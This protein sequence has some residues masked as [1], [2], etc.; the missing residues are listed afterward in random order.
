MT[1]DATS[2]SGPRIICIGDVL[3]DVVARLSGPLQIGS[4]AA[5]TTALRGGGSA[6]NTACWLEHAGA[7]VAL[8]ARVGADMLG[9][10]SIE[11]LGSGVARFVG[12]DRSTPTGTCVVL[13]APNGERTM[14]PD[15][16][17]NATLRP[18]HLH[19]T[20]FTRGGHLH[21]SGYALF[22][23]ARIAALRALSLARAAGMT[24][25]V[26]AAS[27][28]PLRTLG[29]DTFFGLVGPQLLLFANQAEARALTGAADSHAAAAELSRRVGHAVVTRGADTA[30]W[31]SPDGAVEVPAEAVQAMDTTG[32]GDA[33]AAGVIAAWLG[34]ADRAAALRAGHDL[35]ALA[36]RTV[37][38]RPPTSTGGTQP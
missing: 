35:A 17:A 38:A 18:D 6:A 4:D 20:D 7:D 2:A 37:G 28:A 33:F 21:V 27:E 25:S 23:D 34:G 22:G 15:S 11:Q 36:C 19:D 16:G 24:I 32:A 5:G 10:W 30:I 26:G 1:D 9:S 3:V 29:A 8:L 13:V 14:V 12:V 31:C